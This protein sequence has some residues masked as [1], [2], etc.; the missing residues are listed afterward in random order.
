MVSEYAQKFY[1]PAGQRWDVFQRNDLEK[2]RTLADWKESMQDRWHDVRVGKIDVLSKGELH[3]GRELKVRCQVRLGQI[4]PG[5]VA[6]EIY[7]G[8]V[9]SDGRIQ[10]G[11]AVEME[12]QSGAAGEFHTYTG[13]IPCTIS[14]RCGFAIC[15]VAKNED[16]ANK[17]DTGLIRWEESSS[18]PA[19]VPAVAELEEGGTAS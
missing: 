7:Q 8:L 19:K 5:E 11:Q 3:V 12:C 16:L 14:G 10:K 18:A 4:S 1:L 13:L 9:D 6:V 17:Y 2:A 15:V